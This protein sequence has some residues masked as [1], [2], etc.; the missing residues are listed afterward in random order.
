M[1]SQRIASIHL[2]RDGE[3]LGAVAEEQHVDVRPAAAVVALRWVLV[4]AV[5]ELHTERSRPRSRVLALEADPTFLGAPDH[6]ALAVVEAIGDV[7]LALPPVLCVL[8]PG[9]ELHRGLK[10]LRGLRAGDPP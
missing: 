2:G 3:V 6:L 7:L 8:R 5:L 10:G 1:P 9:S 4:G